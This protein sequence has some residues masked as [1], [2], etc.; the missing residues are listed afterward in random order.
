MLSKK[1][2]FIIGSIIAIVVLIANQITIQCFIS[3]KHEDSKI[4]NVAGRQRML[5]QKLNLKY[6]ELLNGYT[7]NNTI[8][9][10]FNNWQ[11]VHNALIYGN[12]N[13]NI[14]PIKNEQILQELSKLTYHINIA[15]KIFQ[16]KPTFEQFKFLTQNQAQFFKIMDIVVNQLEVDA[17]KKLNFIIILEIALCLLSIFIITLEI[18]LIYKPIFRQ[19]NIAIKNAE[20][21]ESKLKAVLNSTTDSN[22]FISPDF[23]I[24]NFNN[25]AQYAVKQFF[26]KQ[27]NFDQD[28]KQYIV[29]GT[30]DIFYEKFNDCLKGNIV[31]SEYNFDPFGFDIWFCNTFYPVYNYLNKIIG[32]TFNST[33]I[34]K[35][36]KAEIKIEAQVQQL[37]DIAWKQS[38]LLRSPVVNILGL[39]TL[40]ADTENSRSDEE[41]EIFMKLLDEVMR[42]DLI[43]NNIVKETINF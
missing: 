15:G 18:F 14:K 3:Q 8:K 7:T 41:N 23:K 25:A 43:I 38:H 22:I 32:V 1:N 6:L 24:V 31:S 37:K 36:K 21:S 10:T 9:E 5:S 28:F 20:S 13:L 19:Q 4:I 11:Q 40:L 12:N 16:Q 39:T 35:R 27:I 29:P 33:N 26:G 17:N 2:N 34:D 30:E 42:L